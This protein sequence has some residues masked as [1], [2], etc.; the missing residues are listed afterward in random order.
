MTDKE[1]NLVLRDI[2]G[3]LP[4]RVSVKATGPNA[5]EDTIYYVCEVDIAREFVTC[6]GQGMDPNI[7]FGFDISQIKPLLKSM[8][9]MSHEEKE[10]Y[11]RILFLDSLFD[12]SSPDLLVDF[13][14]RNGIDY[15]GLIKKELAISSA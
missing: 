8:A 4:W 9:D 15:R 5:Q 1:R 6:I 14:H 7:K 10:D 11:H 13:F 3:R 2:C 12:K